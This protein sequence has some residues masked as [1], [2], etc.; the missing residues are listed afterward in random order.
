VSIELTE[1]SANR[2]RVS[3]VLTLTS[4][5]QAWRQRLLPDAAPG[6]ELVLDLSNVSHVDSGG[7]ALLIAWTRQA[8]G[9]G[10]SLVFSGVSARMASLAQVTG[11]DRVLTIQ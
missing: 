4:V 2:Y 9:A 1:L 8:R 10:Y 6:V 5:A 3:G 11:V 7:L